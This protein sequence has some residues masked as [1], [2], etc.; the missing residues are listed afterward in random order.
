MT[1][2]A[3]ARAGDQS[4]LDALLQRVRPRLLRW[5]TGRLPGWA[6]DV[7]DT[8][9]LL[10]ETLVSTVRNLD[11][12]EPRHEAAFTIYLRQSY[13]NR[14]RD[15][16]RRSARRPA[17]DDLAQAE[18]VPSRD[19]SPLHAIVGRDEYDRYEQ[20]LAKLEPAEREAVIGRLELH[21]SFKELADAWGKPSDD[22]ARKFVQRAVLRL[23]QLM[24]AD[25]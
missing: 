8:D 12:F 21:Y 13:M 20:A 10:Q 6:R 16:I 3:Q 19:E 18:H 11:E 15:E 22:A 17:H 2:L 1:L 14:V 24:K 7:A 23:A 4:A 5:A 25:D 9:D